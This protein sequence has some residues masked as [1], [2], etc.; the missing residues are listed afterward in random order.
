MA[1]RGSQ[2][3]QPSGEC[4]CGCGERVPAGSFWV[5]SHDRKGEGMLVRLEYGSIADMLA[6][7]GYGPNG[8]NLRDEFETRGPK[9]S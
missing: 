5:L 6:A 1:I 8:R 9:N 2:R 4:W 3:A 7:H